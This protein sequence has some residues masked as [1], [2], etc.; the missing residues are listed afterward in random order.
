MA[1]VREMRAELAATA[2]EIP[3]EVGVNWLKNWKATAGALLGP[4]L[5][6]LLAQALTG[7]FSKVSKAD[8][9]RLQAENAQLRQYKVRASKKGT[10]YLS[11][12]NRYR[13]K[14]KKAVADFPKYVPAE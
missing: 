1:A 7:Q 4:V 8:W 10:F 13:V 3:H 12:I 11:Q 5:L 14:N 6:V 9:E 2:Q